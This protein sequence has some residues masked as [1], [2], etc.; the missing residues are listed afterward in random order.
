[1]L[2]TNL[3]QETNTLTCEFKGHFDGL[4]TKEVETTLHEKIAEATE[5]TQGLNITFDLG[6]V[7]YIASAF[8][9]LCIAVAKEVGEEHFSI[10][11]TNPLLK[12]TFKIAGLEDVLRVS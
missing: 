2:T 1:M 3:N 12:K 5:T 7:D 6:N 10:T 4:K 8:I 11:N 9:G